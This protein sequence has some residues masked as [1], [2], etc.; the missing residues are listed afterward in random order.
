MKLLSCRSAAVFLSAAFAA[1][2]LAPTPAGAQ[3][4]APPFAKINHFLII[5]TEN[6][7]LDGLYGQFPG[8]D[9]FA[10]AKEILPQVD[11]D[12]TVF[13][14]LPRARIRDKADERFP[15]DLANAPFAIDQYVSAK[16]KT[17]DLVHKFY[18]EQEQINGGRNDR[19]AAISDAGG[20]VMGYYKGDTQQLWTIAKDFTLVDHFHHGAF[21]SSFLNHFWLVCAC[22]PVFP[23]PLAK[24]VAAVDPKTGFLARA[25]DS[26]KSALDG[27]PK[28]ISDGAVTPDGFAV[29][30]VQPSYPPY[31]SLSQPLERL[32][33]QTMPTIGERLSEKKISWAWYSGGWN[34]A[35]LGKIESYEGPDYF[36]PHHQ[37]FNYFATYAPG[38]K[39]RAEHLQ[40]LEDLKGAIASGNL[41]AVAFYKPV[42]RDNEHPGYTNLST[43][44]AHVAELI[45][46]VQQSRNWNDTAIIVTADENGGSWDSVPPPRGDRWGPGLR[47]PTLIVSPY[48]KH[49]FVDHTIYDTTS[50][51]KTIELRY[52]LAPLGSRDANAAD[53]GNAFDFTQSAK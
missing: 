27:P 10:S 30:T 22:T 28:W 29:N 12:G 11:F 47:V 51:L 1:A 50:I 44:D 25:S 23:N 24:M 52:G 42:G 39:A 15:A 16:E 53:L 13:K 45:R 26:P 20:L 40:D 48:A 4:P 36:Q 6:R 31:S 43:G 8:A 46:L 32:P 35:V 37:P 2:G 41:P 33:P 18:Q 3:E 14:T 9:N 21:G 19:F 34:Q 7:S 5:Y 38:T 49:G 17:G